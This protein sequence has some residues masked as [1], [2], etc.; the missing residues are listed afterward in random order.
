[1]GREKRQAKAKMDKRYQGLVKQNSGRVFTVDDGQAAMEIVG[2]RG[3][4]RLGMLNELR[5]IDV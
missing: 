3:D 4:F 2:T 1:M 5:L